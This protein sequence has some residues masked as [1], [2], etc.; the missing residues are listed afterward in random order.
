MKELNEFREF[1]E[2]PLS[3]IASALEEYRKRIVEELKLDEIS[4]KGGSVKV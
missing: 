4:L 2:S 3:S 1:Y